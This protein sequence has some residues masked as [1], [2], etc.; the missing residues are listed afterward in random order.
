MP[1][2]PSEPRRS[3]PRHGLRCFTGGLL[4]ALCIAAGGPLAAVQATAQPALTVALLTESVWSTTATMPKALSPSNEDPAQPTEK[5]TPPTE[6]PVSPTPDPKPTDPKPTDPKPT[7]PKPTDPKQTEPAPTEP[8][9]TESPEVVPADDSAPTEV[10]T[11]VVDPEPPVLQQIPPASTV[12]STSWVSWVIAAAV[13]LASAI[14]L[15]L[16]HTKF[17]RR[18]LAESDAEDTL[19]AVSRVA[20]QVET[21]AAVEAVGDAMIDAG[22]S[23]V[24]VQTALEDI[25]SVNGHQSTEVVVFPTALVVSARDGGEVRTG[26]ISSGRSKLLLHQIDALDSLVWRA[27]TGE[28]NPQEITHGIR[29]LR[30]APSPYPV[31]LRVA[32]YMLLCAGIAVLLGASWVGVGLATLFGTLVGSV[33]QLTVKAPRQYQPLITVAL[34]F[35]V[36]VAVFTLVGAG[37][38]PGVLPSLIAP[39]VI[40][41][42]GALLTTAVIE[43][44]TGQM[45]SGA[46]RLAAGF[47]QLILLSVG[48]V[49]GA[50]LVGVPQIDFAESYHSIG[51][52]A[53]WV[54][55]AAFGVGIVINQSGR[56]ASIPW[57]LLVLYVAYG[58]QVLGDVFFGG[59]LS[60][61]IGALVMT[62]FAIFVSRLP[63]GP[64]AVVSFLPAFW[65]LVPGALGLVGITSMLGGGDAGST[66]LV[67]TLFTMVAIALG[68]LAGSA[69][70]SRLRSSRRALL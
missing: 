55:V 12:T 41:L 52:A 56:P 20:P 25:A 44:S 9:P 30:R 13:L 36:S 46:G 28:L 61:L 35:A 37:L 21:F 3:R 64:A 33:L 24:S 8:A 18:F 26:A 65:L 67:T 7:D 22:Y 51:P 57:I 2:A 4:V 11:V 39:L 27:R 54:A 59:V 58:A 15:F 48:I 10:E 5:P 31:L 50:M 32:A 29:Q 14:L 45:M 49:A 40:L 17:F 23:V 60:A 53:P 69:F 19:D 1:G 70:S 62:P 42:P 38:D 66:T 34:S 43:L 6:D 16:L 47:M 68:I 63:T